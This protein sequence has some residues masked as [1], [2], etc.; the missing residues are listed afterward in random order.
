MTVEAPP[1]DAPILFSTTIPE[2]FRDRTYLKDIAAMP[3]GPEA[4]VA[5]FKKLD[6]AETLIGKKTG[7][8][9]A[10]APEAE[11]VA[12]HA[13]HRPAKADDYEIKT[14]EGADPEFVKTVREAFYEAGATKSQA[15]KILTKLQ[16]AMD[17]QGAKAVEA[18][19]K[20]DAEFDT[21]SKSTFGADNEKVLA[22][23]KTMIAEHTPA[24][25]KGHVPKLDNTSLVILAGILNSIHTKYGLEDKING[26]GTP[27][28]AADL[29][30]L[31]EEGRKL[32]ALPEYKDF[33]NS[34]HK[35]TVAR[36]DAIYAEI[37]KK[38]N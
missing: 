1:N 29:E 5:L 6:G 2:E 11:W 30:A 36:V 14:G 23:A 35:A 7:V 13:K 9:A 3:D 16:A 21:L 20:L 8:P 32:M 18:G 27:G 26:D 10:D 25:L 33:T 22:Q 37:G 24:P 38:K 28:A 34:K 19:K 4:R 31:H 12:F 15:A 17:A